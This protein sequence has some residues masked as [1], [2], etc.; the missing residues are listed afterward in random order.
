[1]VLDLSTTSTSPAAVVYGHSTIARSTI[2]SALQVIA[3]SFVLL[4]QLDS[5]NLTC[6]GFEI[7]ASRV[8][9]LTETDDPQLTL[10]T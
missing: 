6:Q 3:N 2:L 10:E 8:E 9:N 5:F 1:M 4:A 7:I